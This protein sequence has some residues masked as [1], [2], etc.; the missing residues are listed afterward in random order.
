MRTKKAIFDRLRAKTYRSHLITKLIRFYSLSI[1]EANT[2]ADE[3]AEDKLKDH[4]SYLSEGQIWFTAISKDEPAGKPLEKCKKIRVKLTIHD[5]QDIDYREKYGLE[6]LRR[7]VINRISWEALEQ[8]AT[9]T[10]EDI[11][12]ILLI[13]PSTVKRTIREFRENDCF[14]PLRGNYSDIGPSLSHKAE[15]LKR[16]LKGLTESE[17]AL[18]LGHNIKSIERYIHDFCRVFL[19]YIEGYSPFRISRNTKLSEKLVNEYI[20]LY[21]KYSKLPESNSIFESLE[22]RFN[23]LQKKDWR[24]I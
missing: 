2:L 4:S 17:I 3:L 1:A 6:A 11:S 21:K 15:A 18:Q 12:Q 13:S 19:S 7:M 10:Q 9:L 23:L 14:I 5:P 16:Y 24:Q 22:I 20:Y 8:G